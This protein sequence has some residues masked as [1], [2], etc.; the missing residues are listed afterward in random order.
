MVMTALAW[1]LKAWAALRLPA[2]GRCKEKYQAEKSWLLGM[3]F[4]AFLNVMVTI[5]CQMVRQ[6]R[7]VVFRVFSSSKKCP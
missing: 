4:K 5:P 2:T 6:A 1:N 7:R 3:E